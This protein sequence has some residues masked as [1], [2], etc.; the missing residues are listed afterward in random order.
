MITG[1]DGNPTCIEHIISSGN[2]ESD[3]F[4]GTE[5]EHQIPSGLEGIAELEWT[6]RNSTIY[7][8][9]RNKYNIPVIHYCKILHVEKKYWFAIVKN[10]RLSNLTIATRVD[11]MMNANLQDIKQMGFLR[12]QVA[13]T[14]LNIDY[15]FKYLFLSDLSLQR[16]I[17]A[18][19]N[20]AQSRSEILYFQISVVVFTTVTIIFMM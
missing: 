11:V 2:N 14:L 12:Q 13:D 7:E 19:N 10:Q 20:Y 16:C 17:T 9:R 15:K 3:K 8:L 6:K 5:F 4:T 18:R 1:D